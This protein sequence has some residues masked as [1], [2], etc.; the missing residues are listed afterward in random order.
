MLK[1]LFRGGN[2]LLCAALLAFLMVVYVVSRN[3]LL[4]SDVFSIQSI[5]NK[6]TSKG[7]YKYYKVLK[8]SDHPHTNSFEKSAQA[9]LLSHQNFS[10]SFFS[11]AKLPFSINS[12]LSSKHTSRQRTH[13]Q[14]TKTVSNLESKTISG[15]YFTQIYC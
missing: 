14:A 7:A 3:P 10:N 13:N 8:N 15:P 1:S 4:E 6:I 12:C 2:L 11:K 5:Y 9:K